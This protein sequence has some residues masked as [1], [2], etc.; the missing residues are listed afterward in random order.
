MDK[1]DKEKKV[2][3]NRRLN[4]RIPLRVLRVNEESSGRDIFF[5]Y[6][7][8]LSITGMCIQTSNPKEIG[9]KFHIKFVL[10][11]SKG[12]DCEAEVIWT[13]DYNPKSKIMPGMG[14]KF[15][16]IKPGIQ[17]EIEE[18]IKKNS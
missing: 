16:D 7:K 3:K 11:H 1:E 18:Y 15:I 4:F 14:I 17:K 5:G 12:I 9:S 13:N 8:D 10:P 6:A 2:Q